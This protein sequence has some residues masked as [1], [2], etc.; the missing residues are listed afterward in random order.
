MP[1]QHKGLIVPAFAARWDPSDAE[2][3]WV[4]WEDILN[5][6]SILTS[7]WTLPSSGNWVNGGELV[8][9][10]V[11]D[12]AGTTRANCN[13]VHLSTSDTSGEHTV[14]NRVT[15]SGSP[16]RTLERSVKIVIAAQ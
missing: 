12:D 2:Y 4:C 9:Q 16:Q 7:T 14:T 15:L 1:T 11:Q 13:G 5:G 3:V 8:D 10:S 6:A